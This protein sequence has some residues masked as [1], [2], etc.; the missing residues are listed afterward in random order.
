[1][2]ASANA[3]PKQKKLISDIEIIR[4]IPNDQYTCCECPMVPE[5]LN[6]YYNTN[7]IEFCCQAHGIKK[8]PLRDFFLSEN[9]FIYNNIECQICHKKKLNQSQE[10]YKY[11][12]HCKKNLCKDC[13][14]RHNEHIDI[15]NFNDINNRCVEHKGDCEFL[16][17]CFTCKKNICS[18]VS[19]TDHKDHNKDVISKFKPDKNDLENIKNNINIYQKDLELLEYLIKINKTLVETYELHPNNYYHNINLT[20]IYKSLAKSNYDDFFKGRNKNRELLKEFN[21]KYSKKISGYEKVLN[22]NNLN[23]EDSGLLCL[24]KTNF[25]NLEILNLE[26]NNIND[27][28]CFTKWKLKRLKELNLSKNN[29]KDISAI[30]DILSICNN[31][32]KINLSDNKINDIKALDNED[33]INNKN[34]KEIILKNNDIDFNS[35]EVKNILNKFKKRIKR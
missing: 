29:I 10:S 32:E 11:C 23:M 16:F 25:E 21:D 35:V 33:I 3:N 5:I 30:K 14:I 27:I 13:S 17:Y 28:V 1:M 24:K 7:E 8:L 20:N 34:L 26:N 31:I 19:E 18:K 2:G 12:Y 15:I 4:A 9:K 6:I 22:L